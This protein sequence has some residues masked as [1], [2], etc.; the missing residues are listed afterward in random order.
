MTTTLKE[1]TDQAHALK[2]QGQPFA[3]IDLFAEVAVMYPNS[4]VAEHNLASALGDVGRAKDAE[5][6]IRQ[7]FTK[8]LNAPESC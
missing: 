7:A 8:G 3:A 4:S 2:D 6:H 1:M 5:I